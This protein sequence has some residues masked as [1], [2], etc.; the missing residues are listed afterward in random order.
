MVISPSFRL[1]QAP[2][3]RVPA[4]AALIIAGPRAPGRKGLRVGRKALFLE[5][6]GRPWSPYANNKVLSLFSRARVLRRL[7]RDIALTV[8]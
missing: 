8:P 3:L 4:S 6:T 2:V 7:K 5:A 1:Q